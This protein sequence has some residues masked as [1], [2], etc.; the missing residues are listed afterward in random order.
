MKILL[1]NSVLGYG[2]TGRIVK[3]LHDVLLSE[4][5]QP[6][7]AFGRGQGIDGYH[8]Y[9]IGNL[10]DQGHHLL[11]TRLFDDH[12]LKSKHATNKLIQEIKDFKPDLIH[13]HNIHGYYVNYPILMKS[14]KELQIPVVWTLHDCWS[15]TGHCAYFDFV[16]CERWKEGCFDCPQKNAYPESMGWDRS[17]RNY[18]LKK[19]L[20]NPIEA[21]IVSPSQ[22]LTN[23]VNQSFLNH[24]AITIPNGIDLEIFKYSP[25]KTFDLPDDKTI[26]LGV[27]SV[28]E[29][30]KGLNFFEELIP[31]LPHDYHVVIVGV[32]EAQ[33]ASLTHPNTTLISRTDN[34][35]QL[36]ELYSRADVLLNPTLEDN[37]PTVNLEAQACGLPIITFDT[38][39]SPETITQETGLIVDKDIK[40]ILE[41]LQT[42]KQSH[43]E[44]QRRACVNHAKTFDKNK[45]YQ[46][47]I[48]LYERVVKP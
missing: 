14:I 17:K 12:G 9:K 25:D 1:I 41:G 40:S 38:G 37:F 7:V 22:W 4:N 39:G 46:Q 35:Q 47:Y 10:I 3:D 33:K 26:I 21:T 24:P 6:L 43:R 13:L 15:F 2:S 48:E 18:Q 27:A 23:L 29:P 42:L 8:Q 31:V 19:D 20:F 11:S 28:W 34:V 36:V 44:D 32:S 16:G 30:R 5:H 45:R